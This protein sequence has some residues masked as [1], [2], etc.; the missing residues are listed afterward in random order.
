VTPVPAN[1]TGVTDLGKYKSDFPG[2][3]SYPKNR[4]YAKY[5]QCY[6][7][8]LGDTRWFMRFQVSVSQAVLSAL[9]RV[10]QQKL[11]RRA[12]RKV[13]R[14]GRTSA[15]VIFRGPDDLQVIVNCVQATIILAKVQETLRGSLL[16]DY[17]TAA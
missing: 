7:C 9:P 15:T 3:L 2:Q 13:L 14:M 11:A 10:L 17:R 4:P 8:C 1:L 6:V 12:A 5:V 16:R